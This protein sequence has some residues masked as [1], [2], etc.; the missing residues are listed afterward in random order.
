MCIRDS[1]NSAKALG[2]SDK[3]GSIEIGKSADFSVYDV[4]DYREL[5]YNFSNN[6]N[7]MTIKQGKVIY[8][9]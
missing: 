8:E 9:R 2:I 6:L 7:V 4:D 3:V 1:I 5:L